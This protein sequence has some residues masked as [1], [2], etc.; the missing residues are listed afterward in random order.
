MKRFALKRL[1]ST[2]IVAALCSLPV[3]A[4]EGAAPLVM[5]PDHPVGVPVTGCF[6]ANETLFG[7]YWLTFCLDR[8]GSFQVRG[9]GVTCNGRMTWWTSGRDIFMDLDRTPCG[10]RQAWEAASI[11][12]RSTGG[13]IGAIG[14]VIVGESPR[15]RTLRCT[16]HPTVPGVTRR[17]F[18]ATRT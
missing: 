12:C 1:F 2:L 5:V 8:R 15:I 7:P 13:L 14:R 3:P 17:T 6:R 9:G 16:Y 11:D 4:Q 18:T 10:G